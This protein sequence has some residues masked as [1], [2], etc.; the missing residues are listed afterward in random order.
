MVSLAL[1]ASLAC[2]LPHSLLVVLVL[3]EIKLAQIEQLLLD[4][5]MHA[6]KHILHRQA[7]IRPSIP[8]IPE[9]LELDLAEWMKGVCWLNVIDDH[10]VHGCEEG[11]VCLLVWMVGSVEDQG[12]AGQGRV[13]EEL[14]DVHAEPV[15]EGDVEGALRDDGVE[16]QVSMC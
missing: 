12:A 9:G 4:R 16:E 5:P 6:I 3:L 8:C 10:R 2:S 15:E 14:V 1:G 11:G 7:I 13:V